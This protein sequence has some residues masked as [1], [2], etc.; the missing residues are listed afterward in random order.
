M[1]L[2][3]TNRKTTLI[4]EVVARVHERLAPD[5]AAPA[6]RFVRQ[7]YAHVPAHDLEG[8]TTDGLYGAALSLWTLAETRAEEQPNVRVYNPDAARDGWDSSHTIVEIVT[9]DMPFLFDSVGNWLNGNGA[10]V[11]LSIHPILDVTRNGAGRITDATK[12]TAD[13]DGPGRESFMHFA[14]QEQSA[15]RIEDLVGEL[16]RVLTDV[17]AAVT[18]FPAMSDRC[19]EV[20]VELGQGPGSDDEAVAFLRWLLQD[21][22]TFLGYRAYEFEGERARVAPAS[23]MGVLRGDVAS[24]F[25]GLFTGGRRPAEL[26][27]P[28][29]VR[30]TK[31]NRN[32]TVHRPV[33]MDAIAVK[34]YGP[35]GQVTGEHLFIGLFTSRA[36]GLSPRDVPIIRSKV[37]R[38]LAGTGFH[39]E[40]YNYRTLVH[41]LDTYPRDELYQITPELLTEIAI[42][43]LNLHE[44]PN[45]AFFARLDPF[46]RYVSCLIFVPR[47][48]YDTA[49]RL[50]FQV[51][52]ESAFDGVVANYYT[53]MT[54]EAHARLHV[55]VRT[56]P[57]S[58]PAWNAEDIRDQLVEA[59]RSWND[60]LHD[61]LI[62]DRGE[63]PGN[64]AFR[65]FATAFPSSYRDA[66]T[67]TEALIDVA[68]LERAIAQDAFSMNLYQPLDARDHEVHFKLYACGEAAPLSD[69]LPVL[70]NMGLRVLRE[71]PYR[72]RP[73]ELECEVWIRNFELTSRD[74]TAIDLDAIRDR[75][76]EAFAQVW[77]GQREND[78]LNQLVL[79]ASLSAREVTVLRAYCKYLRQA[80]VPFSQEYMERA[81]AA[82]PLIARALLALFEV[83]F[84][85][86]RTND[87]DAG[88]A[89][90]VADI[91]ARLEQITSL[92]E[93]RI[94]RAFLTVIEAT[95]RT[96]FY[97]LAD[98]GSVKP[99][100]SFKLDSHR[101]P[102]LPKP[103]PLYE[104]FVYSVRME[105]VHLRGGRV[106]R[107]G[108]RWSDRL[109]DFRTE[110]HGLMKAQMVK[111]AVIVPVGSKGGFVVKRPPTDRAAL[112]EEVVHCYRTLMCG[113]LDLTD[114]IDGTKVIYPNDVVRR[115]EDDPYLV[116]AADKG[117]ATFSDTANGIA[118]EYG[119]WLDDAFASGGS[120]GYD[121]KK[122]AI[123][124]RGGWESVKRHF[125]EMNKN[126]QREDFT[127]V[128]VGDMSGDVFGNA[129]LLSRHTK[130]LAAFNH[131]HI[132]VDPNPDVEQ[133][134]VERQ[135]LFDLQ[136]SSWA[137]YNE[138][139]ISKGGGVWSRDRKSI[140]L[141]D[142]MRAVF[143]LE[144]ES[145][146]PNELLTA[147]L[148][149]DVEL[150]WLGGI[151]TYV[152]AT[153]ESDTA[154]GDRANDAVRITATQLR[155]K[156]IGEG[157][158]LG[159]TQTARIEFAL[160]GGRI[161]TDAIDNS[162]GVDCSDHEVNIKIL[163][164]E[165]ERAGTMAREERDALLLAM[166][167]EVGELVLRD[168]YLQT[169][170]LTVSQ[171]F[172]AHLLDRLARF[173]R[174]LEKSGRLDRSVEYLPDDDDL[175][176]RA[177]RGLG[178]TRP[179][180]AILLAYAK[181]D[182]YDELLASALPDDPALTPVLHSYFPSALRERFAPEM[183]RH[184]LHREIVATV[185]TNEIVNRVGLGFAHEVRDK[186]GRDADEIARAYVIAKTVFGIEEL[187]A[188]IEALDNAV[189]AD[190][191]ADML[192]DCGRLVERGTLWFLRNNPDPLDIDATIAAY[193]PGVR[194]V[195]AELEALIADTQREAL[196]ARTLRFTERGAPEDLARAIARFPA[197]T[198]SLDVV[199]LAAETNLEVVVV[200]RLHA[201]VA[202]HF[203]LD[204]LRRAIVALPSDTVWDKLAVSA[205]MEDLEAAHVGL[206]R[207]ILAMPNRAADPRAAMVA[208]SK[209]RGSVVGRTEQML[210]ELQNQGHTDYAM[211]AVAIRRLGAMLG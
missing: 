10:G 180:L 11:K 92:D 26:N 184:R 1:S 203:G 67:E 165:A 60:R 198:A 106:A 58:L 122:M 23:G 57:G 209:S 66:H 2:S 29:A 71:V 82:H 31:T 65:A 12:P 159:M 117:T 197:L 171:Q 39:P 80:T 78:G 48:Q 121:H 132:F 167:D 140:P 185:V 107:G 137:D 207:R 193:Q 168:N 151:G 35:N 135:R 199:R 53:R 96:N 153:W 190:L 131:L 61:A 43:I 166:T 163:L 114:N 19:Q 177:S 156:V 45:I 116:V 178:L 130:L 4:D 44:R 141:S 169:Q 89:A 94:L 68:C 51:V 83:R 97:Q 8:D 194:A 56:T 120:V 125:R 76:H 155:A 72:I 170:S 46:E 36:Y 55:L 115:D 38:V 127:A 15:K 101:I 6:E 98:D 118:A 195:L 99:Y 172:G 86:A 77:T 113:L 124:A 100:V 158:N 102:G 47:D 133:S 91:E 87:R 17:R 30:I 179:E 189:P 5:R 154:V 40:S 54:T 32:S 63:H 108:I 59:S 34:R 152:R 143:E 126:I 52:L 42:G 202:S 70:E 7:F 79:R 37:E 182:L 81:L 205:L 74:E 49:L 84:D 112:K 149:A 41:I 183:K 103:R 14:I 150:L 157:A 187:W 138:S 110:V 69:V 160:E 105:G 18:G 175:A 208:W 75:F 210:G 20:A 211:L 142:E 111:N 73:A 22:F 139:L 119:F 24:V 27:R 21:H 148:K 109:E 146:A 144:G 162:A 147:I 3:A 28:D 176:D 174:R 50:K 200:A 188:R 104:I 164:G 129:M 173:I 25:D 33:P 206:S 123:T 85:P 88:A 204:L 62:E 64:D 93:D 136:G 9:D 128:G 13:G 161:N 201:V 186:T 95:L 196:T 134:F 90:I 145:V 181:M 192:A 16:T 191:Q